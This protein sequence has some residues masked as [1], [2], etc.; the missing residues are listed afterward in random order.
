MWLADHP[1]FPVYVEGV[2]P[3]DIAD[4]VGASVPLLL[5]MLL[6]QRTVKKIAAADK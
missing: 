4:R 3:T 5:G 1:P 2:L 6:R